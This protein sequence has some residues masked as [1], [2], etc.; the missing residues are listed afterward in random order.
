MTGVETM[1]NIAMVRQM[2]AVRFFIRE[3]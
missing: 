1:I 3:F 2:V